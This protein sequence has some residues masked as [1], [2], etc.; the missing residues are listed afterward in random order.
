MH[1]T[2]YLHQ[3]R[4]NPWLARYVGYTSQKPEDRWQNG[5]GYRGQRFYEAIQLYGWDAFDHYLLEVGEGSPT[6]IGERERY[7]CDYYKASADYPGGY[8]Q[9]TGGL[10]NGIGAAQVTRIADIPN[11][12]EQPFTELTRCAFGIW[13]WL[14]NNPP[15]ELSPSKMARLGLMTKGT[16]SKAIHELQEKG[17]LK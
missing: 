12:W 13:L 17:Y 5:N 14:Q 1:Y 16:A 4:N 9:R 7:W 11:G 10:P 6:Y 8:T 2:I 3:L 15:A